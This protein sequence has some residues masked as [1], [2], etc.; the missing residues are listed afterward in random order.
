MAR[1][2][3]W[4]KPRMDTNELELGK[5]VQNLSSGG[6]PAPRERPPHFLG[7]VFVSMG[8]HSWLSNFWFGVFGFVSSRRTGPPAPHPR[9]DAVELEIDHRRGV[10]GEELREQQSADNREAE[11]TP[12][13]RA[14]ALFQRERQRA[15]QRRHG[16]D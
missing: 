16:R 2:C 11:G 9:S 7:T 13:F 15:E 10:K 4:G 1:R 14:V 5:G 3:S 6:H 8:V 12:E